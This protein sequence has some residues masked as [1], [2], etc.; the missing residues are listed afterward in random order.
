MATVEKDQELSKKLGKNVDIDNRSLSRKELD[1]TYKLDQ[2]LDLFLVHKIVDHV[3]Y[4]K[5]KLFAIYH[6]EIKESD[7]E[8]IIARE[9]SANKRVEAV[10]KTGRLE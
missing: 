7:Y 8:S 3:N 1:A 6:L 10:S 5:L 4:D 2:P 9:S